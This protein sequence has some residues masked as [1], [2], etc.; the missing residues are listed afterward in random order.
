[1]D[2]SFS[3]VEEVGAIGAV[4]R[5][6][7]GYFIAGSNCGLPHVP[8]ASMAEA[9]A[10]RDG[11]LLAGQAGCPKIVVNSDCMEVI[12]TMKKGGNS[13]GPAAAIYEECAFLARGFCAVN[14]VFAPRESNQVAHVQASKV[15]GSLFGM[16]TPPPILFVLYL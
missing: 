16:R 14:F 1:M 6:D 8:D 5:D 9:R 13:A 15:E 12:T 11:L 10:L 3:L 2:V 7:R 4:L